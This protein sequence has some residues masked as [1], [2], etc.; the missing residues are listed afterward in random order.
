MAAGIVA[1]VLLGVG[2]DE[3]VLG[4]GLGAAAAV[5]VALAAVTQA[6]VRGEGAG[7]LPGGVWPVL[8]AA[9]LGYLVVRL[10]G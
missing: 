7:W 2:V 1:G 10:I 9:P 3:V 6:R 4:A 5:P 8:L